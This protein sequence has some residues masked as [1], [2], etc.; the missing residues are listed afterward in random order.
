MAKNG[1]FWAENR[2]FGMKESLAQGFPLC[3]FAQG[4]K[5]VVESEFRTLPVIFALR[6][7][8][9]TNLPARYI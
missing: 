7:E 4:L 2:V 1:R 9:Q 3:E 5:E 8:P 6:N